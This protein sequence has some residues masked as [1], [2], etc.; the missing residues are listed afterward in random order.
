MSKKDLA[1]Q[2][3]KLSQEEIAAVEARRAHEAAL[4]TCSEELAAVLKKHGFALQVQSN[5]QIILVPVQQQ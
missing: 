5:P 1:P 3:P 2:P 4:K